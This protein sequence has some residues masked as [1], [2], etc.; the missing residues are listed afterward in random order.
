MERRPNVLKTKC[1]HGRPNGVRHR[2]VREVADEGLSLNQLP[3]AESP[4]VWAQART[5]PVDVLL[6][7]LDDRGK[8]LAFM[9]RSG[10]CM[11]AGAN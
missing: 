11:L 6:G 5:C 10:W 7:S 1:H 3:W 8:A 2:Q 4:K 9:A